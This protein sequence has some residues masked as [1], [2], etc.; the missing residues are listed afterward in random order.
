MRV[1]PTLIIMNKIDNLEHAEP[2]IERDE[3]GVPRRVWVSAMKGKALT[4]CS[5]H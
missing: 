2:R 5:K 1:V 4:C 3:E